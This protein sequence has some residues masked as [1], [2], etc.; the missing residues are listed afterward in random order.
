ALTMSN[1]LAFAESRGD[2]IR[3]AALE[4]VT[5]ART[6]ADVRGVEVHA[7]LAGPPGIA[8]HAAELGRHGAD[9]V[10]VLEHESL[11]RYD[12]EL[13]TV[14]LAERLAAGY[15]AAVFPASAQG[16][17]LTPRVAAR[18]RVGMA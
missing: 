15:F 6:L 3:K 9:V 17:D 2:S 14:L 7:V 13:L 8:A 16:R 11:A 12:A 5:A 18:R 4:A 10:L 1:I